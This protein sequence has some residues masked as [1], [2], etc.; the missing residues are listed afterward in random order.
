M[1]VN[2]V[3][4]LALIA[5][6][7]LVFESDGTFLSFPVTSPLT[8]TVDE[9][10]FGGAEMTTDDL[11]ELSEFSRIVN[12]IPRSVFA[13]VDSVEYLWDVYDE[14]LRTGQVASGVLT[15]EEKTRLESALELLYVVTPEG[16]TDSDALR[17]Y[18][19]HRDATYAATEA[20][21]AKQ[22]SVEAA[23]DPT[24]TA[25]WESEEAPALRAALASLA[26]AWETEGRQAEI[27]AA[28]AVE[29]AVG[30]RSPAT[31]WNEWQKSFIGDIDI[32]TDLNK[33][34]YAP[35]GFAPYDAF[36]E[37]W[38]RFT[39]SRNEINQMSARAPQELIDGLGTGDLGT[40]EEVSFEFRSVAL[41]RPWLRPGVFS[42]HFWRLP[43]GSEALSDGATPPSGRCPA[44][45]SALVFAR[46]ISIRSAPAP[47]GSEPLDPRLVFFIDRAR[48][49]ADR[50]EIASLTAR[51][52]PEPTV[53]HAKVTASTTMLRA[54]SR[55]LATRFS[56]SA[57]GAAAPGVVSPRIEALRVL[58]RPMLTTIGPTVAAASERPAIRLGRSALRVAGLRAV[59]DASAAA[60]AAAPPPPPEPIVV[61]TPPDEIRILA[62]ICRRIGPCPDPDPTLTW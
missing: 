11:Q 8:K 2:A 6:A 51:L 27:E 1:A 50:P 44:Y 38:P 41:T 17:A 13:P 14:V 36:D 31:T 23:Q 56:S 54:A 42:S 9:L 40:I 53:L 5:K 15:P 29:E 52:I 55:L 46:N 16:R 61:S 45:V 34:N 28:M 4:L 57:V 43:P 39:L 30:A 24:V 19:Q 25:A 58:A 33:I 35:T 20:F 49:L 60:P 3:A 62:F 22:L 48:L 18:K 37:D 10:R 12:C 32:E 7:K 59:T 26:T 21:K 47:S